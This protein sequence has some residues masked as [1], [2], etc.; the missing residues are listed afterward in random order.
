MHG[1]PG[2]V[3]LGYGLGVER[4]VSVIEERKGQFRF[5]FRFLKK[6]PAVPVSA[7]GKTLPAVRVSGSSS[8][9]ENNTLNLD[10]LAK[11]FFP[12]IHW[13]LKIHAFKRHQSRN[14]LKNVVGKGF[15]ALGCCF[16]KE[17][18][19]IFSMFLLKIESN[20]WCLKFADVGVEHFPQI[21][22]RTKKK[23]SYNSVVGELFLQPSVVVSY[24]SMVLRSAI[25]ESSINTMFHDV[26][27]EKVI[28]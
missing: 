24:E 25:R 21:K 18:G 2:S 20:L 27:R 4:F 28:S 15:L 10:T 14:A 9:P 11:L 13:G 5:R 7:P 12:G 1:G 17:F 3:W 19:D 22:Q 8:V 6:V 16:A 26:W 23:R